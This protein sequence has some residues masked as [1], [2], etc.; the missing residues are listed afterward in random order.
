MSGAFRAAVSPELEAGGA[1]RAMPLER[2]LDIATLLERRP[3]MLCNDPFPHIRA[4]SV[5]VP[6]IYRELADAFASILNGQSLPSWP[7]A[8]LVRN[9]P[10]YDASAVDFDGPVG[11]PFSVFVSQAWHDLFAR[12]FAVDA[13][14]CV[15]GG[16]HHHAAGS[17]DGFVHNDLNPGWFAAT[18]DGTEIATPRSDLCDYRHGTTR[19]PNVTARET[20]R[21]IA[22]IYYLNNHEWRPGDGGETGLYRT[23]RDRV[24]NP[25]VAVPPLNNSLVAFECTPSSYHAFRTNA[26]QPRNSVIVWLHRQKTA[27]LER[28]GDAIVRW[29]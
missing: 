7:E 8:R 25:I 20:V 2:S 24:A 9:M 3:W 19:E 15:S 18:G 5:F 17:R 21:G 1:E 23:W 6:A 16:L 12:L 27:V 26:R 10:G 13:I 14:G 29:P 28:W 4:A 22:I 11:W